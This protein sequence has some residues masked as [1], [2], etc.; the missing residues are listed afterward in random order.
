MGAHH[1]YSAQRRKVAGVKLKQSQSGGDTTRR[2]GFL[3]FTFF[4]LLLRRRLLCLRRQSRNC[5]RLK[6]KVCR[7]LCRSAEF[8]VMVLKSRKL[9]SCFM[10][11]TAE[12]RISK[13]LS[14]ETQKISLFLAY[15][16]FFDKKIRQT[17]VNV[18]QFSYNFPVHHL[19]VNNLLFVCIKQAI[20]YS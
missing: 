9:R 6:A 13:T 7:L 3:T 19:V 5:P 14:R 11:T 10:T 4:F 18:T 20:R 12:R 8:V 17:A 1:Y 15:S 16:V 2:F